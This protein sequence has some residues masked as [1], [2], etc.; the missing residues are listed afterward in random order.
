MW[1]VAGAIGGI[2]V[3]AGTFWVLA[4]LLKQSQAEDRALSDKDSG[5]YNDAG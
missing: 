3:I 2:I 4:W 5:K 1:P